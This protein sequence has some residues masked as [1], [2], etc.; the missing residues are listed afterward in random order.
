MAH[1]QQ[2]YKQKHL[3]LSNA[4]GAR[5]KLTVRCSGA[6]NFLCANARGVPFNPRY[7]HI[8]MTPTLKFIEYPLG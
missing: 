4:A 6:G 3:V 1:S 2:L 7:W 5:E 8:G